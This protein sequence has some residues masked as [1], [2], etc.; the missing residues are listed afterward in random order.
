MKKKI[1]ALLLALTL[2]LSACGGGGKDADSKTL[3]VGASPVPHAEILNLVKDDLAKEGIDL[4]VQEFTDY[5]LPNTAVNDGELD[6]NFFQHKP[7]LDG[8]NK[9]RG[10]KLVAVADIHVEPIG[11]YSNKIK[12][13][14]EL[15]DGDKVA[16]PSDPT[17]GGRALLLL[18]KE[19]L[20]SV[21]PKAGLEVTPLDVTENKLNLEFVELEAAQIPRSLDDVALAA[22]NT[23][24]AL[25]AQIDPKTA[26]ASEDTLDNPYAN[27]LVVLEGHEKDEK[28]QKLIKA[29]QSDKVKK[30]IEENY[31]GAVL[32]AF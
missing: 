26:I 17:N 32:P 27:A 28:I 2:T 1:F 13:L 7:Y 21:D 30:F 8:F 6:A 4:Q 31:G 19:G 29:L 15:K 10:T 25:E 11:L 3:K 22:I 24:Y 16:I 18:Q 5:V 20:I 12:S 23:N 14:D 9:E